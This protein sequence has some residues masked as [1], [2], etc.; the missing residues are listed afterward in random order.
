MS[1]D[2]L[3]AA[4]AKVALARQSAE[5]N[6]QTKKFLKDEFDKIKNALK[7]KQ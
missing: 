1:K 7:G 2:E 6:D 5:V 3:Q 4:M